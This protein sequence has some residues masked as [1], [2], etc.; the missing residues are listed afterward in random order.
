MYTQGLETGQATRRRVVANAGHARHIA[1]VE[2]EEPWTD[3]GADSTSTADV[4][5]VYQ[6]RWYGRVW[7]WTLTGSMLAVAVAAYLLHV[8]RG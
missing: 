6:T 5:A 1:E 3:L 2:S 8:R 7:L 4:R